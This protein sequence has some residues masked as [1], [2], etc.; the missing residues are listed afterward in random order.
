MPAVL[1]TSDASPSSSPSRQ[2]L[3]EKGVHLRHQECHGHSS[4]KRLNLVKA[5]GY[6]L[7]PSVWLNPCAPHQ[8]GGS[9]RH[10]SICRRH[11]T[12][13]FK[14][15]FQ[16][17]NF[18]LRSGLPIAARTSPVRRHCHYEKPRLRSVSSEMALRTQVGPEKARKAAQTHGLY[19]QNVHSPGS[20]GTRCSGTQQPHL[21][22]TTR[23]KP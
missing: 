23:A 1:A 21:E 9:K 11:V 6:A 14:A 16:P 19:H 3:L 10:V 18:S 22:D 5:W 20:Y 12:K 7:S 17:V 4:Q 13:T 15:P 8:L 2:M